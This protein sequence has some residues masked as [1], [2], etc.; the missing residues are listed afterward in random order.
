M[1]LGTGNPDLAA[2]R[3]LARDDVRDR[4]DFAVAGGWLARAQRVV[5]ENHLDSVVSGYLLVPQALRLLDEGSPSAAFMLFEQA[6]TIAERFQE[7]DLATLSRLD[8]ANRSSTRVRSSE[9]AFLDDAMLAVTSGEVG[10]VVNGI[11][12]CASIE[13]FHALYDLRRA[14]GWT[15]A[16]SRWCAAQPDMVPFRGR[17]LVYRA[18][19]MRFHGAWSEAN[20]EAAEPNNGCCDRRPSR[21]SAGN[22]SSRPSCCGRGDLDA[23]ESAYREHPSGPD[24]RSRTRDASACPGPR[25]RRSHDAQ[26]GARRVEGW[27]CRRA[28]PCGTSRDRDRI[29]R[30]RVGAHGR[31]RARCAHGGS[32]APLLDAIATRAEATVRLASGDAREASPR[33]GVRGTSGSRSTRHTDPRASV[34]GSR[35]P[36]GSSGTTTRRRSSWRPRARSSSGLGPHSMC[37]ASTRSSGRNRRRRAGSALARGGPARGC[38]G[39][40]E[41]RDRVGARDQRANGRPP[42][43]QYLHEARHLVPGSR[44]RVRVRARPRLTPAPGAVPT[45][46]VA[47]IGYLRRCRKR[48]APRSVDVGDRRHR[49]SPPLQ[50]DMG[51]DMSGEDATEQVDTVV[52]GRARPDWPPATTS[53]SWVGPSSSW[54][55]TNGSAIS[56]GVATSRSGCSARHAG[57]ACRGCRSRR[58]A[59]AT[60]PVARWRTTSRRMPPRWGCQSERRR[61]WIA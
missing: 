7:A 16:L 17:C 14:Q 45:A 58:P 54:T 34:S 22:T 18:E 47:Q 32:G 61:A 15:D 59:G 24:G 57:T 11:V 26:A 20:E 12:Y 5:E 21:R 25:A 46:V 29:G 43:Q 6:A 49:W 1:A 55:R 37:A 4:G 19:L 40:H 60:P 51:C 48:P 56:G 27:A 41:P 28:A 50:I 2:H 9:V 35:W 53:R 31:R 39:R 42:R 36:A 23:A 52:I 10:P 3:V 38:P 44:D 8:Q 33:C 30:C 13:S